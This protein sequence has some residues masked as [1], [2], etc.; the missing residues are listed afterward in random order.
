MKYIPLV[1]CSIWVV[2]PVAA[3][4]I[5]LEQILS[6]ENPAFQ[7]ERARLCVGRDG[8]V[9]LAS[10]GTP[11]FVLRLDHD[12]RGKVGATVGYALT[13]A[14]ANADGVL[15]TSNAHFS[16]KVALYDENFKEVASVSDFLV[17]D[18]VG[19]GAPGHVE[20]GARD[21]FGLDQHRYRIVRLGPGGK[22]LKSYAIPRGPDGGPGLVQDFR[23]CEKREA[24][25]LLARNG[26]LRCIG[27]DGKVRWSVNTEVR[28]GEALNNG[29]FDV[30]DNGT[31]LTLAAHG[32]A[33]FRFAAADGRP[34]RPIPLHLNDVKSELSERPFCSLRVRGR[35]LFV[36]RK[37]PFELYRRY[38]LVRGDHK[39][40]I[41]TEHDRLTAACPTDIWT[42]GASLPFRLRLESSAA[43]F[44]PR[45]RVWGR[46]AGTRDYREMALTDGAITV[47]TDCAGLFQVFV[48]PDVLPGHPG[49]ADDCRLRSWVEIRQPDTVGS[50]TIVTPDNRTDYGRG[51]EVPFSVVVRAGDANRVV[52][53]IVHLVQG[54]RSLAEGEFRI[55]TNDLPATFVLPRR[56]TAALT[57]GD[58]KLT[59]KAPGLTGVP[60]PLRFGPGME[61]VSFH[62]VQY[63][64]YGAIYPQADAW[65]APDVTFAHAERTARLGFNLLVDRLGDPHQAGALNND[66]WQAGLEPLRKRLEADRRAVAPQKAALPLPLQQTLSAYSARGI[67]QMAILMMNDAGLPLGGPGFDRRTPEELL[68]ALTRTTIALEP[69]PAFRGWS[70]AS[71]WWIFQNRGAEASKS[72]EEKTAYLQAVKRANDTGSWDPVLDR[73][74][75]YRLGYAVDA[76][77]LFNQRLKEIAPAW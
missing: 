52:S 44:A 70:W 7:C 37:H 36:R 2:G 77:A 75:G 73:V 64:D 53:G 63:G 5:R 68:D 51:E 74:S 33:V 69:Y 4:E 48:T 47:P 58:Y 32:E 27:F 8:R 62:T 30:D 3:G 76:Q 34:L 17:D 21:F 38:D 56:L 40:T 57:P 1:V 20:A 35:D 29:G 10:G 45:W 26:P 67:E 72:P 31:L 14:A 41:Y 13:G 46:M 65:T 22:L 28:W 15:A 16:H 54:Q 61:K 59:V 24:F 25:Y 43:K 12:G 50:A 23:V 6:R 49:A 19:W 39:Q 66:R 60:A 11:S 71:N 42:A 9:Y 18:R 55:R